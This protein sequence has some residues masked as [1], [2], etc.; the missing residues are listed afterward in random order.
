MR[1][2]NVICAQTQL[3]GGLVVGISP[4]ASRY[5]PFALFW[6]TPHQPHRETRLILA[7]PPSTY[8]SPNELALPHLR[9]CL[10]CG[11]HFAF[12]KAKERNYGPAHTTKRSGDE[13][14][15]E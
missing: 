12:H 8:A 5:V 4:G 7:A 1:L 14:A 11:L 3:Y 10:K 6:N 15:S 9:T 13:K 2:W